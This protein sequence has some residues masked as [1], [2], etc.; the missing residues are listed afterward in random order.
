MRCSRFV[1]A[2]LERGTP[3][4]SGIYED[5]PERFVFIGWTDYKLE[6]GSQILRLRACIICAVKPVPRMLCPAAL[7]VAIAACGGPQP[8]GP[9][10]L[11]QGIVIFIG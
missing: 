2:R 8:L 3:K 9:T 10:P 4:G 7:A 1:P 11:D 5:G 6:R